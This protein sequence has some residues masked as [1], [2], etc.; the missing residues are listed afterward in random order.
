[1]LYSDG[2]G[3]GHWSKNASVPDMSQIETRLWFYYLVRC[4]IDI[5]IEA[6]HFGQ[7]EI[8]DDND[9]EH[10]HWFDMLSRIRRYAVKRARRGLVLC[11]AHTPSG[12]TVRNDRL[13]FDFHSFPLRVE[14]ALETPEQG[15]L[16]MGH[17]DSLYGHSRGGLT[18]SGWQ[19]ER[20]PY[21]VE[22]DNFGGSGKDGQIVGDHWIW[23][24]D[25]IVWFAKQ[26]E[27]Y[28]NL[29][30]HYAWN[31]LRLHDPNGY[32]QMPCSR[33]LYRP[34]DGKRWYYANTPSTKVPGG[35]NQEETIKRIWAEQDRMPH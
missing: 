31:W 1:M 34:V 33:V 15:I 2:H 32:L 19:C 14:E 10:D 22:F 9:P 18:P 23:G 5:G 11:D 6:I 25:E 13:L 4:Y 29:W 26:S 16:R 28:R 20:L 24:Y 12:G 21:L 17:Y 27:A 8:M 35:F 3:R 30:L 7:V